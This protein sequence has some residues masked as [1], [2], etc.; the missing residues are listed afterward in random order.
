MEEI[1]ADFS[2]EFFF[3]F[4]R[5]PEV[6]THCCAFLP[7]RVLLLIYCHLYIYIYP[8]P[9]QNGSKTKSALI[10]KKVTK[11]EKVQMNN[12]GY[13][14]QVSYEKKKNHS[15]ILKDER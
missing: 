12:N 15:K 5:I 14:P 8:E 2:L 13:R 3:F 4:N 9:V 7:F 10:F 11:L 1:F 6:D